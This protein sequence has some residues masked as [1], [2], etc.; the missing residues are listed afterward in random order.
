[1]RTRGKWSVSKTSF[2][3]IQVGARSGSE[4]DEP[5]FLAGFLAECLAYVLVVS[6]TACTQWLHSASG[7]SGK[8]GPRAKTLCFLQTRSTAR[9]ACS[10]LT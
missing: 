8:D 5:A 3:W 9:A 7:T 1:M 4:D 6:E 10:A 2:D